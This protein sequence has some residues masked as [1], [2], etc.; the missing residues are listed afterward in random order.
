[1]TP[2][3]KLF[4]S[5][6]HWLK[7]CQETISPFKNPKAVKTLDNLLKRCKSFSIEPLIPLG[8]NT[9]FDYQ[10]DYEFWRMFYDS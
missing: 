8:E 10:Y 4:P 6:L 3:D 1:M 2:G 9:D 7:E 5:V